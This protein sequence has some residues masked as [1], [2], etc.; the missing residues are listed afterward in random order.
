MPFKDGTYFFPS[1]KVGRM[2]HVTGRGMPLS[3]PVCFEALQTLSMD[4]RQGGQYLD[5][6]C[7]GFHR[8]Q[9]F[10]RQGHSRPIHATPEPSVPTIRPISNKTS[11][12]PAHYVSYLWRPY[13]HSLGSSSPSS[14]VAASL[15]L[16]LVPSYK[17]VR[18]FTDKTSNYR[19]R[20]EGRQP[21][22][23]TM[24]SMPHPR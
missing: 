21:L 4:G 13:P 22:Q 14:V 20:K 2:H 19:R 18:I 1:S 24:C 11:R 6:L 3:R 12:Y 8:F 17:R 23:D 10:P 5:D 15:R 7:G 16:D 9:P